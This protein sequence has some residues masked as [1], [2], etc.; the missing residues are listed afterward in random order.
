M[1]ALLAAVAALAAPAPLPAPARV[2]VTAHEFRYALSRTTIRSGPVIVELVNF[3][4]DEHDLRLRRNARSAPTLGV[5]EVAPGERDELDARLAP[6]T[7][8]LWCSL[9]GHA[10]A[11]MRATLVVT[12]G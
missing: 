3:G 2:Q 1:I 5:E 4:E 9:P 11:G 8:R 7:Y 10:A 6:G 12:R